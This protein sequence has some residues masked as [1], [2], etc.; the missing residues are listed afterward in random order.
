MRTKVVL[1][2]TMWLVGVILLLASARIQPQERRLWLV[3]L[4]G[5]PHTRVYDLLFRPDGPQALIGYSPLEGSHRLALVDKEGRVLHEHRLSK[6]ERLGKARL[7]SNGSGIVYDYYFLPPQEWL[8]A[9]VDQRPRLRA[10]GGIRC[11]RWDGTV[12]WD[13]KGE[14]H[15]S[16]EPPVCGP[17]GCVEQL[18]NDRILVV[19]PDWEAVVSALVLD[20]RG[21][22]LLSLP[23]NAESASL[24]PDGSLLLISGSAGVRAVDLRGKTLWQAPGARVVEGTTLVDGRFALLEV[25]PD[26]LRRELRRA[27]ANAQ[28]WRYWLNRFE[29]GSIWY[30]V[31]NRAGAPLWAD[32]WHFDAMGE[33]R[34]VLEDGAME[35]PEH[36]LSSEPE[37]YFREPLRFGGQGRRVVVGWL[38]KAH[39]R[40]LVLEAPE[41]GSGSLVLNRVV[42]LPA[43]RLGEHW[44]LSPDGRLIAIYRLARRGEQEAFHVRLWND[45]G[46]MVGEWL[47][48]P[49]APAPSDG[50][51]GENMPSPRQF[52]FA[53]D[54]RQVAFWLERASEHHWLCILEVPRSR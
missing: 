1:Y 19:E 41:R 20:T 45:A 35:V 34:P 24:S 13:R 16:V 44:S 28:A 17:F 48:S 4:G 38:E 36:G 53:P 11:V 49:I 42:A 2:L 14:G 47:F 46:E 33:P 23:L 10:R 40:L 27:G 37:A 21:R 29:D 51:L 39:R 54:G 9:S 3:D 25:R 50:T 26:V 22:Q 31:V 15:P 5:E 18:T 7:L 43:K 32:R 12:L 6:S 8:L 30:A 52:W